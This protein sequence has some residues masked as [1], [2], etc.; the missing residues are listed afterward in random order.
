MRYRS[1]V[2]LLCLLLCV[3]IFVGDIAAQDP[4][5]G[6]IPG[7][8]LAS[9]A[10]QRELERRFLA[11]PSSA[12]AE[13]N[14]KELARQPHLAGTPQ[15]KQVAERLA[16]QVKALGFETELVR[17][18]VYLPH[19][20]RIGIALVAPERRALMA[21][22]PV[23]PESAA[24]GSPT[25]WNWN[26]YSANGTV[27]A[28]VVYANYGLPDDYAALERLG[29]NV[30]GKIVLVRYGRAYRGVKVREA[31]RRGAAGVL[32]YSEPGAVELAGDT[33]P[34]GPGRP[35]SAVQRGTVQYLWLYP[36]DPLTPGTA[37]LPGAPR[38]A[39]PEAAN[40]P[41]IPVT[42]LPFVEA[43]RIIAALGGPEAP[44]EF[45]DR[46]D[47]RYRIGPGP[48]VVR[49]TVEQKYA[50]RPI[51][52]VVAHVPG[53]TPQEVVIGNHHDAWIFGGVDPHSGTAAVLEI[54]RGLA[55]VRSQGWTPRRGITLAFWDAEEFGV[56][57]STEWVEEHLLRLRENAV[58]YFNIDVF[59]A[60][61]LDVSGSHSLRDLV[62][63]AA[64]AVRDPV[65]G[66]SLAEGWRARQPKEPKM[67]LLGNVGPG[68][69]G[70]LSSTTRA[71]P[72]CSGQ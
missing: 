23:S 68:Q 13:Q 3:T 28:Q 24:H 66:G 62:L 29:Q 70:R 45:R 69:T 35:P 15:G 19:P 40:L 10:A 65:T 12:S 58:A 5:D 50:F 1:V 33:L 53:R 18:D 9:S 4:A 55:A 51:W 11:V 64:E 59:L 34:A 56:I 2:H 63:G 7:F 46:P 54:A 36:G 48:A 8:G 52:T 41:R 27:E 44:P 49:L 20:G 57:G 37:A 22:E 6:L 38:L 47:Q 17:H 67:P 42:P 21:R 72:R 30:A 14:V 61:T 26:A 25:L 60:G 43:A 71:F 31:E 39:P 32:L 16:A